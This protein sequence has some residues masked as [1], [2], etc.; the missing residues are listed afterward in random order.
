MSS[1]PELLL[2][3]PLALWLPLPPAFPLAP[4]MNPALPWFCSASDSATWT[5]LYWFLSGLLPPNDGKSPSKRNLLASDGSST[6]PCLKSDAFPYLLSLRSLC[7]ESFASAA[8]ATET[9]ILKADCLDC[10]S[11]SSSYPGM[12]GRPLDSST[13][14]KCL[15]RSACSFLAA[16]LESRTS[17]SSSIPLRVVFAISCFFDG[18]SNCPASPPGSS[19]NT[20]ITA[21]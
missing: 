11:L 9:A 16:A 19:S 15:I 14:R 10:A 20:D 6:L 2:S 12:P 5:S 17:S 7:L 8:C 18:Y 4:C 13:C 3:A 21:T 1:L